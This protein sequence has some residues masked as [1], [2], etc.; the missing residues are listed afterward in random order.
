VNSYLPDFLEALLAPSSSAA[1][2]VLEIGR[3][4]ALGAPWFLAVFP[5]LVVLQVVALR[6]RTRAPSGGLPAVRLPRTWRQNTSALPIVLALLADA[7]FALALARPLRTDA[8]ESDTS[9]GVDILL[10]VDRSSSMFARDMEGPLGTGR[11]R[12]EV[13][14]EVALE[15]AR[16]RMTD[17]GNA[18]DSV[19]LLGFAGYPELVCPI[20]LDH[21]ALVEL[22]QKGLEIV[23]IQS[24]DGT[25]IGSA[26]AKAVQLLRTSRAKSRVIVL[27]SDGEETPRPLIE[28]LEAAE[29]AAKE[30]ISV[31]TIL[32]GQRKVETSPF[33]RDLV[34]TDE[35]LDETQM[36]AIAERAKGR[37]YRAR[38]REQLEDIYTRIEELERT[39]RETAVRVDAHDLYRPFLFGGLLS[40]ALSVIGAATLW[41]RTLA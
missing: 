21:D 12:S 4:F 32:A 35:E 2:P 14:R 37:F 8:Q 33:S 23:K 24:E 17:R 20:T 40:F 29:F 18:R 19:G 25:R 13:V 5:L 30:G 6:R 1:V 26:L 11:T 28:P 22:G 36:R 31:H 34:L 7:L 38:D 27:L 41:R 3:G 10:V 9:E 39:P 16:R 15:F